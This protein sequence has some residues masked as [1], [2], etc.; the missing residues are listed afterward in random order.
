MD[1]TVALSPPLPEGAGIEV[2]RDDG[3]KLRLGSGTVVCVSLADVGVDVLTSHVLVNGSWKPPGALLSATIFAA[4]A[5]HL[6]T[7]LA[8]AQSQVALLLA[9]RDAA[10]GAR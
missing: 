8:G 2:W 9:E 10:G 1:G 7:A 4:Y 6:R 5:A 3:S